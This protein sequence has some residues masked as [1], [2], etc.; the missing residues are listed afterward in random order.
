MRIFTKQFV[1]AFVLAPLVLIGCGGGGGGSPADTGT[2]SLQAPGNT[3]NQGSGNGNPNASARQFAYV[4]GTVGQIAEG[5][6]PSVFAC[7]I[8]SVT[9]ALTEVGITEFSSNAGTLAIAAHPTGKFLFVASNRTNDVSSFDINPGT[10]TL[11]L[12]GTVATG[13][14][15]ASIMVDRSNNFVYVGANGSDNVT[16]SIWSY[17]ISGTGMLIPIGT[18]AV[19]I[20]S[21]GIPAGSGTA[22]IADLLHPSG[23]FTYFAEAGGFRAYSINPANGNLTPMG[24]PQAVSI[25]AVSPTG[26]FAYGTRLNFDAREIEILAYAIGPDGTLTPVG[27]M[28]TLPWATD[29]NTNSLTV[30]PTGKFVY[31]V[32]D[33]ARSISTY[34]IASN[35]TLNFNSTFQ[36]SET[37]A[38]PFHLTTSPT[39]KFAY[40]SVV[41]QFSRGAGVSVYSVDPATGALAPAGAGIFSSNGGAITI[42]NAGG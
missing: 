34:A 39:G 23:Q 22:L 18:P 26:N 38:L 17:R 36:S 40:V 11:T 1:C 13:I 5:L 37:N 7:N 32:N 24:P 29:G 10:G 2:G 3:A 30:D 9:G 16:Y 4:T 41:N 19:S 42:V 20:P 15:P 33:L 21:A 8:D 35:G 6:T 25:N 31:V 27:G 28:Q 12:I 14:S